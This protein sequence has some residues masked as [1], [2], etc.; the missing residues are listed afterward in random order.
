MLQSDNLLNSM[1]IHEGEPID[2]LATNPNTNEL[3]A[4]ESKYNF[5]RWDFLVEVLNNFV[6]ESNEKDQVV[7]WSY[8]ND[9]ESSNQD[10]NAYLEYSN[11]K[12]I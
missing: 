1:Y 8:R 11:Y 9:T 12:F 2:L 7:K 3:E 6:L 10:N 5:I 4:P